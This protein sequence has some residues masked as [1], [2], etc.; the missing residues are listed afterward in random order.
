MLIV[1]GSRRNGNSLNLAKRIEEALTNERIASKVIVPGNQKIH[2]CTGCMDCDKTQVC[3]FTDDMEKNIEHIK[4]TNIIMF[5]TP[6]RWNLL[7]GD[8]KVFLDRLN[9]LFS[10]NGLKGKKGIVASIGSKSKDCYSADAATSSIRDFFEAASMDCILT[11]NFY[12]CLGPNDILLNDQL[13]SFI[14]EV[15]KIAKEN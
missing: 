2:I 13:D 8:L 7:S 12:D 9:P 11:H 14:Q 1:V 15:V 5:I 4:K 10:V 6:T 3:D